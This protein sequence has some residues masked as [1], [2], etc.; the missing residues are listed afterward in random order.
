MDSQWFQDQLLA[1]K[2]EQK[3]IEAFDAE[4]IGEYDNNRQEIHSMVT[5]AQIKFF[6]K[7]LEEKD[8]GSKTDTDKLRKEFSDLNSK[9]ASLWIERAIALPKR[10][11]SADPIT[12]PSF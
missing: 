12:Q 2:N 5:E 8:F 10:D 3:I 7:L 11:D 9:S 6:D 4:V 1:R